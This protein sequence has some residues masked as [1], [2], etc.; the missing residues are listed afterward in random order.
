MPGKRDQLRKTRAAEARLRKVALHEESGASIAVPASTP[1]APPL[2][3]PGPWLR[4]AARRLRSRDGALATGYLLLLIGIAAY[5]L[6]PSI[7]RS[8]FFSSDEYVIIAE[9]IRFSTF[10]FH[11]RFFDMP[12]TPL[13]FLV[14]LL[15]A[16][17]SRI[18]LLFSG[19]GSDAL[20]FTYAHLPWLFGLGRFL[21]LSFFAASLVLCFLVASRVLNK[22]GAY[23]ATLLVAMS[24]T[25]TATVTLIRVEPM[26]VC[27]IL[28]ALLLIY[29]AM[30]YRPQDLVSRPSWRDPVLL[31]GVAAGVG[32]GARLHTMFASLPLLWLILVISSDPLRKSYPRWLVTWG[33]IGVPL[34]LIGAGCAF[35]V[36]RSEC[37]SMPQ[38]A[39]LIDKAGAAAAAV[40]ILGSSLYGFARTRRFVLAVAPPAFV[41][42][43]LGFGVGLIAAVPTLPGQR[44]YFLQSAQGYSSGYTDFFRASWSV[45]R[46]LIWLV[47]HYVKIVA[48]ATVAVAFLVLGAILIAVLRD[49]GAI[50]YLVIAL[51][52]FVSKPIN[53]ASAPHHIIPWMPYYAIVAAYPLARCAS[54]LRA[55]LSS[56]VVGALFAV[57]LGIGWFLLPNGAKGAATTVRL[58]QIRL[59]N[60]ASATAWAESHVSKDEWFAT[61]YFCLNSDAAYQWISSM[62]VKVPPSYFGTY[63]PMIWWGRRSDL[64]G[65][66][67]YACVTGPDVTAARSGLPQSE[68]YKAPDPY[69]DPAFQ[70]AAT[71]GTG[72]LAVDVFRFDFR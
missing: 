5:Y 66:Y 46:S 54:L 14:T 48:P 52:F 18:A 1:S 36:V 17:F 28:G 47:D 69:H 40:L 37:A 31:A 57:V 25:Y 9:V 26:S 33:K 39:A 27:M 22:T 45:W 64:A 2:L 29:F 6:G 41:K 61:A 51:L 65:R 43:L 72:D 50:P 34:L 67:G 32:A 58:S 15:W 4:A 20:T 24:P 53:L 3:P 21:T 7:A 59:N 68:W 8:W 70:K 38:A 42:V 10:D 63:R 19:S 71:F 62:D 13:M 30:D 60:V 56:S 55:R 23:F 11:Q 12:G 49:R 16:V 35:Y 44:L